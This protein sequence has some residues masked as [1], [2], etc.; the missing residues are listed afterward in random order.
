MTVYQIGDLIVYGG[1]GVCRV[2]AVG[3]DKG[4]RLCYTLL[5]LYQQCKI[6]TPVDNPKVPVRP[7]L[8]RPQAEALIDQ[9]PTIQAEAYHSKVL[10]ELTEHYQ[11]QLKTYDCRAL[12][13]L[14]MSIYAKKQSAKNGR[15][16]A[17]DE[18]YLRRAEDLLF[19]ELAAALEL[20]RDQV[21][22]YI[23]RR[24]AEMAT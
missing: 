19:S 8:S 1:N 12:L 6:I 7:A 20:D 24:M 16:G 4:G 21:Q 2:E 5:P 18:S 9:I 23:A 17:V 10:R 22:P 3:P 13:E 14:T 15:V 11:A